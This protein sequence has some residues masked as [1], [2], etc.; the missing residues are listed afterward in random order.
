MTRAAAK[1]LFW[2][3]L[4]PIVI[5]V[6]VHLGLFGLMAVSGGLLLLVRP[7]MGIIINDVASN[8][9]CLLPAFIFIVCSFG[10]AFWLDARRRRK[11]RERLPGA[12]IGFYTDEN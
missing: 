2:V 1:L 4:G 6:L 10:L 11:E 12:L 5:I 9:S 3:F 8:P 7:D